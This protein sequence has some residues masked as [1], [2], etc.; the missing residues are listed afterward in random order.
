MCKRVSILLIVFGLFCSMTISV[1]TAS[2]K[3]ANGQ[4][5]RKDSIRQLA[6]NESFKPVRG[7]HYY[8][9]FLGNVKLGKATI[10]VQQEGESYTVKVEAR[11]N[12]AIRALYKIRY[13][14]TSVVNHD[15]LIPQTVTIMEQ[16]GKKRKTIEAEY[17][18]PNRVSSVEVTKKK[19]EKT[20]IKEKEFESESFLLDPFST[21]FLIRSLD[22]Q[23]GDREIFDIF[24]GKEQFEFELYCSQE[25][26]LQINGKSRKSWE[27]I[28]SSR[29]LTEPVKTVMANWAI[30]L[31]Q[32]ESREILQIVG[33]PKIGK[34][35]AKM[36]KFESAP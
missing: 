3:P 19:G 14:G 9:V 30:Y 23:V 13:R 21:V 12:R 2:E 6:V 5:A 29:T 32:D 1:G 4:T 33:H 25:K 11:T 34:I 22:W 20:N 8:D 36:R 26:V 28:P 16:S 27:I 18:A 31:S 10:S 24:T 35:V 17:P 15:P 7:T